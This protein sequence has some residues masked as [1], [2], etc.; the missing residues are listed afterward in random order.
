CST[1]AWGGGRA[2]VQSDRT[3][4]LSQELALRKC[5]KDAGVPCDVIET[6]CSKPISRW[7]YEKPA[8]FVPAR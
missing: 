6:V 8:D 5:A 4:E 2:R 1:F 3:P 7:V